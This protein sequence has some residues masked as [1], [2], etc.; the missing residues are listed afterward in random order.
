ME[1]IEWMDEVIQKIPSNKFL[2]KMFKFF[3]GK[4][5]TG[6]TYK[7]MYVIY[8]HIYNF[9]NADEFYVKERALKHIL[10]IYYYN[11]Q[12]YPI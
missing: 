8:T 1:Y 5:K 7:D 3:L 11:N 10:E 6:L 12:K 4:R 9:K 2:F